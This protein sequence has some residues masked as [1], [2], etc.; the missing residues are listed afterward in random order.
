[1]IKLDKDYAPIQPNDIEN[2]EN[3][4]GAKLP[5]DYTKFMLE[6]NGGSVPFGKEYYYIVN[7]IP[8]DFARFHQIKYGND[9]LET[10]FNHKHG[11]LYPNLITIGSI[12]GGK[13]AMRI[14]G[15]AYGAIYV[16]YS[17]TEPEKIADSFTDFVNGLVVSDADF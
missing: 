12:V 6:F 9:S 2:V 16:Y 7:E 4:I 13:L 17:D 15:D 8:L 14:K 10:Y 1:M 3:L 5:G 11:F